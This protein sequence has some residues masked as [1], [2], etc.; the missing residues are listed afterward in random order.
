MGTHPIFESDFDCLT[1][2]MSLSNWVKGL[3][4]QLG[5]VTRVVI[6][7]EA[8]DLDSAVSALVMAYTLHV[9]EPKVVTLPLLNYSK[10][11]YSVKTE[12]LVTLSCS[13]SPSRALVTDE[14]TCL[15]GGSCFG[16]D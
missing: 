6:G 1:E 7:N 9:L 2:Y 8:G 14:V 12:E 4:S 13:L 16:E 10:S 5:S 11:L 3:K 15:L